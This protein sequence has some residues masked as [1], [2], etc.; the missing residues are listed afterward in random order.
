MPIKSELET[1]K[2]RGRCRRRNST[3]AAQNRRARA[4]SGMR[5]QGETEGVSSCAIFRA[6]KKGRLVHRPSDDCLQAAFV[7]FLTAGCAAFFA[8]SFAA[9]S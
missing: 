7:A 5:V 6:R 4:G 3:P 1:A 2:V 9:N 8:F